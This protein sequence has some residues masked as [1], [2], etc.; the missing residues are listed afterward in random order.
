MRHLR[1]QVLPE[2][3]VR[4]C[5]ARAR[6]QQEGAPD[7]VAER[8]VVDEALG[9]GGAEAHARWRLGGKLELG[10]EEGELQ[11]RHEVELWVGLGPGGA[12]ELDLRLGELA[13]PQEPLARGDLVAEGLADLRDAKRDGPAVL[14]VAEGVVDE[15]A[16][17]RLRAEVPLDEARGADVRGEH[18]VER[19]GLGELVARLRATDIVLLE[20]GGELLAVVRVGHV[21]HRLVLGGLLRGHVLALQELLHVV[22]EELVRAVEELRPL[23][24]LDHEV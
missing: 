9:D 4:L 1:G 11:V 6:A 7:E 21:E 24:V 10:G 13:L 14:L 8:L 15:Y 3:D 20:H 16:L 2:A 23:G 12:E 5:D 22:L 18:E 19:V 17:G